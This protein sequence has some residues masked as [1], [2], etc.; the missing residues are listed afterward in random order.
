ML[1]LENLS[2]LPRKCAVY[3]AFILATG[4]S[5]AHEMPIQG[6]TP[7]QNAADHVD[8]RS[9]RSVAEARTTL[10]K[11]TKLLFQ[12]KDSEAFDILD[13]YSTIKMNRSAPSLLKTIRTTPSRR[14]LPFKTKPGPVP[15]TVTLYYYIPTEK[16]PVL[17]GYNLYSPK[18]GKW[19]Y[20]DFQLTDNISNMKIMLRP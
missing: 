16:K 19:L 18:S 9:F 11:V 15:N 10:M 2:W 8:V 3:G 5:F 4:F 12:E 20:M 14:V 6:S 13:P 7:E 17:V 1:K